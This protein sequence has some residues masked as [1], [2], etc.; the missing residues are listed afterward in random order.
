MLFLESFSK[1]WWVGWLIPKQGPK[2]QITPQIAFFD[3]NFTIFPNLTKTL[4]WLDGWVHTFV[5][6]FQKNFFLTAPCICYLSLPLLCRIG[7]PNTILTWQRRRPW[8][9]SWLEHPLIP[10][11]TG[12]GWAVRANWTSEIVSW[13]FFIFMLI[14]GEPDRCP[15]KLTWRFRRHISCTVLLPR[16]S[17]SPPVETFYKQ[18]L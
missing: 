13:A 10:L 11:S 15:P 1:Y 9:S 18:Y 5:K 6:T 12:W 4:E 16:H 7:S 2:P 3:P 14:V 8:N 17:S